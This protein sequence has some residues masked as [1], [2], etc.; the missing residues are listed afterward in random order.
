MVR[1]PITPIKDQKRSHTP[2]K[3][4]KKSHKLTNT[5]RLLSS[6]GDIQRQRWSSYV[7]FERVIVKAV[8]NSKED[9]DIL[10]PRFM[11][12]MEKIKDELTRHRIV[13]STSEFGI[14]F[15]PAAC[16][17]LKKMLFPIVQGNLNQKS[18]YQKKRL[19]RAFR[20]LY[21]G[22]QISPTA[23]AL[24][25][26]KRPEAEA[27]MSTGIQPGAS[28]KTR[29]SYP[30]HGM[31]TRSSRVNLSLN[32]EPHAGPS[33][34][35]AR[36]NIPHSQLQG[37]NSSS[38]ET[39]ITVTV[40][41]SLSSHPSSAGEAAYVENILLPPS[42]DERIQEERTRDEALATYQTEIQALKEQQAMS[43]KNASQ[44]QEDLDVA[45]EAA[46]AAEEERDRFKDEWIE[47][48]KYI[49]I[50]KRERN[51]AVNKL[52]VIISVAGPRRWISR[53][54]GG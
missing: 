12:C 36:S 51:K 18:P 9:R 44:L 40:D 11:V 17:I 15:S 10:G 29:I 30:S 26:R 16:N 33:N 3:S 23:T 49:K 4:V 48:T 7:P 8:E 47:L 19:W 21:S 28:K 34:T 25:K 45:R 50:L 41:V 20:D 52:R 22:V 31:K 42:T 54:L 13:E 27:D 53:C 24:G 5:E 14:R 37:N 6:L 39:D 38:Q 32:Q 35:E 46:E 2:K 43:I 1:L